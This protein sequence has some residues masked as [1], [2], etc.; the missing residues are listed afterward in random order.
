MV[1]I[2]HMLKF[3]EIHTLVIFTSDST[4]FAQEQDSLHHQRIFNL[5]VA[6]EYTHQKKK[7]K[8]RK[9]GINIIN[10]KSYW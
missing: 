6:I 10:N 7:K 5:V 1:F 8:E 9:K 3:W 4:Y 2:S